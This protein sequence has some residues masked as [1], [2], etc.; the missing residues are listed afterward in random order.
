[1]ATE[2][3]ILDLAFRPLSDESVD[4]GVMIDDDDDE[5]AP[6]KGAPGDGAEDEEENIGPEE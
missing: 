3:K 6:K 1:M 5:E 2:L 4:D